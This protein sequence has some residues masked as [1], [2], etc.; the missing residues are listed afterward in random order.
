MHPVG[1]ENR[2]RLRNDSPAA[3][4]IMNRWI[5]SKLLVSAPVL[6]DN[7][8]RVGGYIHHRTLLDLRE[9]A[10][11]LGMQELAE[12]AESLVRDRTSLATKNAQT[13]ADGR[14]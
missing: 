2:F 4:A 12:A 7:H 10:V 14:S 13:E 11:K 8:G 5:H 1:N 6:V 3:F 9:L